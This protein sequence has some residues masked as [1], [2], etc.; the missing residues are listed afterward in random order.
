MNLYV[1]HHNYFSEGGTSKHKS[2]VFTY[3]YWTLIFIYWPKGDYPCWNQDISLAFILVNR[4][5]NLLYGEKS[6]DYTVYEDSISQ[7]PL[8]YPGLVNISLCF[9]FIPSESK[10]G[11]AAQLNPLTAIMDSDKGLDTHVEY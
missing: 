6:A 10:K 8:L 1:F 5:P 2:D 9:F 11:E 3:K 4:L 7:N